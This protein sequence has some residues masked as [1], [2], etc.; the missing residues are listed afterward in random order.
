MLNQELQY[1]WVYA[2]DCGA[3]LAAKWNESP[4]WIDIAEFEATPDLDMGIPVFRRTDHGMAQY[5]R[6]E[7]Y[8][9]RRAA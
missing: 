6:F 9:R 1:L 5:F 2:W 3:C 8:D 7:A 4:Q